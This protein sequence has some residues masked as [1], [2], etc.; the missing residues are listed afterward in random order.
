[1]SA[2]AIAHGLL[3]VRPRRGGGRA[4][5]FGAGV[6]SYEA[7]VADAL[8]AS[9]VTGR[10]GQFA[11]SE[12]LAD[13]LISSGS[14]A[15]GFRRKPSIP[16]PAEPVP[17]RILWVDRAAASGG[18]GTQG[19]SWNTISQAESSKQPGD[20]IYLSGFF[21]T[22]GSERIGISNTLGTAEQPIVY[23]AWPGRT[24]TLRLGGGTSQWNT[25]HMSKNA[26]V[27]HWFVG[28]TLQAQSGADGARSVQFFNS[29]QAKFL[30]CTF[31]A[32]LY[33]IGSRNIEWWDCTFDGEIG[34]Q[35]S[36][37][38]D[39]LAI[40]DGSHNYRVVRCRWPSSS[41]S[42]HAA[43]TT[44]GGQLGDNRVEDGEIFDCDIQNEWAGG[45]QLLGGS[46][47][48][49][50]HWNRIHNVGTNPSATHPPGSREVFEL[51]SHENLIE[52]NQLWNGGASGLSCQTL[53]FGGRL[54]QFANNAIRHNTI[55]LCGGPGIA[56]TAAQGVNAPLLITGNLFENNLVWNNSRNGIG[57][58]DGSTGYY[59]GFYYPITLGMYQANANTGGTPWAN[60]NLY[61]NRFRGN[62][63]G[64]NTSDTRLMLL[65]RQ[66]GNRT[67]TAA[68]IAAIDPNSAGNIVATDP[69]LVSSS[70]FHLQEGSPCIDAG[71]PAPGITSLG[72]RADIGTFEYGGTD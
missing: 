60:D 17:L 41:R 31:N 6:A 72:A 62:L 54:E 38:G 24:A 37:S 56:I 22:I 53:Y 44:Y 9:I 13:F 7:A 32:P 66:S 58:N 30:G 49:H 68:Q 1:M 5:Y 40:R 18:N 20:L 65:I 45:L 59:D 29:H 21:D 3:K 69:R 48:T 33:I 25:I 28:L 71:Y 39:F 35:A 64:V 11:A 27:Y 55:T 61:G 34:S 57:P 19:S 16:T 2:S 52:F 50:V 67:Y 63:L 15:G 4:S 42:G 47:R 26:A 23:K 36:N 51:A 43:F 46:T 10:Y 14:L 70:D 8:A 12:A